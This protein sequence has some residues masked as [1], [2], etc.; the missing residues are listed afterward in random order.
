MEKILLPPRMFAAGDEPV[1][2]RIN[3][4]HKIKTTRAI[5]AALEQE[6]LEFLM[7]S[8]FGRI[9]A[10]DANPP[11]SRAF[12]E[13]VLVRV[14]KVNKKY[15]FWFLFAGNPI[16][17]SLREFAIVTGLNCGKIPVKKTT[18]NPLKEKLY[19]NELF[20]SLKFC[21][22][23]TAI[24]MLENKLKEEVTHYERVVIVDS[25]SD[26]E[27][28]TCEETTTAD[29]NVAGQ[30]KPPQATKFCLIPGHAKTADSECQVPVKSILD[31]PYEEWSAGLDFQWDDESE[32]LA[33]DN[34]VRLILEGF[35][36]RKEIKET[37][38]ERT[39]RQNDKDHAAEVSEGEGSSDFLDIISS[40]E[41]RIYQALDAKLEKLVPPTSQSQQAA[42]LQSTMS[43][44]LKDLDKK[45]GNTSNASPGEGKEPPVFDFTNPSEAA[46]SRI[47]DVLRD[48]NVVSDVSLPATTEASPVP[49]TEGVPDADDAQPQAEHTE[50]HV[51]ES[52]PMDQLDQQVEAN[53]HTEQARLFSANAT[54]LLEET[55]IFDESQALVEQIEGH[56]RDNAHEVQ[57]N[58]QDVP[59]EP[60]LCEE[61]VS[62]EVD[63]DEMHIPFY[64]L[65]M[66]SFSLGLSQEDSIVGQETADPTNN[67]P[68]PMEQDEAAV[69]QRKSKRPKIALIGLQDYKC[70]SKV[71]AGQAIIPDLDQ[72]FQ[73]ME[74]KLLNESIVLLRRGYAVTPAEF[75]DIAHRKSI[76]LSGIVDALIGVVNLGPVASPKVVIYDITL[77]VAIMDHHPRFVKTAVKDRVKLK[78]TNIPLVT[79]IPKVPE[80]IYFPFNM[81]RQHWV[82]V[83]IDTKAS[84]LHVLDCKTSIRSD[85]LLKNELAPIANLIPYVLKYLGYAEADAVM[86]PFIVSSCRGIPQI[87][88][89]TDAA[90][91][92]VLFIE[93]HAV[94]GLVGC[95]AVTPRL[96]PDAS[97]HLAVKLFDYISA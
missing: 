66:P 15:D 70:D 24:D 8:T 48:L 18:K 43:R 75:C 9:L 49:Q 76:L 85:S 50:E 33:F 89:Q 68:A 61:T 27:T 26:G 5:I 97:K 6:E 59:V 74:E 40:L 53:I 35:V 25:E 60:P 84:T 31:D 79:P 58:N 55:P 82:G 78:F 44:C 36:F 17:I 77:P 19:W 11:F 30:V 37:K 32:D 42:L 2:E 64:L 96:L 29:D 28:N 71:T 3:S 95:K 47:N 12:G 20:G 52:A 51:D 7:N 56:V 88:T 72:R 13:H 91:M 63:M 73:L 81:D 67:V 62:E 10:I 39:E 69:V 38:G 4:Y 65:E 23:D 16:R 34:M 93:A 57:Q 1:G 80:R 90:V 14:L 22:V 41:K 21:T 87:S 86:K 94:D 54:A 83:C 45:I 46:D 92:T